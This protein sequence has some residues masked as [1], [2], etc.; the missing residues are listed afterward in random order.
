VARA[1]ELAEEMLVPYVGTPRW[2][3]QLEL[4][5][6]RLLD[7]ADT[8]AG[9][10]RK[11][12][13]RIFAHSRRQVEG[14]LGLTLPPEPEVTV[15]VTRAFERNVVDLLRRLANDQ[16]KFYREQPPLDA[17]EVRHMMW[18]VR[19]RGILIPRD[20]SWKLAG[21]GSEYWA[22]QGGSEGYYW[23]T[24]MDD[25]VRDAHRALEGQYFA[26]S[27]PPAIGHPGQP[28]N[29]RCVAVLREALE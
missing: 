22:A 3:G 9:Q 16:A 26:W 28:V 19:V 6:A 13:R 10:S 8:M 18:P 24:R 20:Q 17:D 14:M 2:Q 29:C 23:H 7:L 12:A 1:Q 11:A 27:A 5:E 15:A 21:S 25:R 4:F